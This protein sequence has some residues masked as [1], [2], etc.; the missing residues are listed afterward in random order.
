MNERKKNL[1]RLIV[2]KFG[3]SSLENDYKIASAAKAVAKEVMVGTN[4]VVVVSAISKSTDFLLKTAKKASGGE[5]R[6][7]ELDDILSMGERTSARIFSAALKANNINCY[8]LDPTH[9][10]WP[11]ITDDSFLNAKPILSVCERLIK[12]HILPSIEKKI[13]VIIPGF[14]GK[15]EDGRITT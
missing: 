10:N 12:E 7:E 14:I 5:I 3:G 2:V 1:G 9:S 6:S 15:T 8:Y 11:I 13:V 4:V